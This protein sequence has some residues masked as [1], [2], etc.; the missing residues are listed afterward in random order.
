MKRCD[1]SLRDPLLIQYHDE[2][3][4]VPAY[5]DARLFEMLILEGMQA[6][7]SW[8][9]VL[10][11]RNNFYQAFDKF[12]ANKIAVYSDKHLEKLLQ[13]PGIIRN[14]LKVFAVRRNAQAF[15]ALQQEF[16][17]FSRYIWQFVG[18]HPLQNKWKTLTD[19]PATSNASDAMSKDLKK[20]GFT[21]VGSSICYAF[22]QA[23]GMVNDHIVTCYRYKLILGMN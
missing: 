11:K 20:R 8:L 1:W 10:K 7:L 15:L 4:G 9:T 2:E 16:G 19:V 12:D 13:D 21:F 22:M 18:P 3:W 6:G 14:K 17:Q 23:V 5:D